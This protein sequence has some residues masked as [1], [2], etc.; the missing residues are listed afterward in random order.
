VERARHKASLK[1]GG[2]RQR[3]DLDAL[4]I[5]DDAPSQEMLALDE[6]LVELERHDPRKHQVVLLRFFAG[7]T[8]E[9][10]AQT[11]EISLTTVERDWRYA[12]A[13]LHQKLSDDSRS[14]GGTDALRD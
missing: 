3:L 12:R 10:T 9:Q 8:A 4:T 11:M 1:R 2:E 7:C 5:A 13:W 6:A 14:E